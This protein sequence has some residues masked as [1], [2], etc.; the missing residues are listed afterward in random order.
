MK[1]TLFHE[2][3]LERYRTFLMFSFH[4]K[5]YQFCVLLF[6]LNLSPH[7]IT[8]CVNVA[9]YGFTGADGC[10]ISGFTTLPIMHETSPTMVYQPTHSSEQ[11]PLSADNH[12]TAMSP[13][14]ILLAKPE[15]ALSGDPAWFSNL[16]G[17]HKDRCL[18]EGIGS[19]FSTDA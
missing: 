9:G 8:V 4:N 3:I 15:H 1:D 13:Q 12:Y 19:S 7:C 10:S 2:P 6:G 18:P 17:C 11:R 14:P 5:E 16:A